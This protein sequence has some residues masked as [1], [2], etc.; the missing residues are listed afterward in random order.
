V[1]PSRVLPALVAAVAVVPLLR[2]V[3][4]NHLV[5]RT[6]TRV[7]VVDWFERHVPAGGSVGVVGW[8]YLQPQLRAAPAQ[9][10]RSSE[11]NRSQG[12]RLRTEFQLAHIRRTGAPA[13]ET[14]SFD[15]GSWR[16]TRSPEH[17]APAP[18]Q[19]VILAEHPVWTPAPGELPV[20]GPEYSLV[21][22]FQGY[23]A[24][25]EVAVFDRQDAVYFPFARFDGVTRPGP[26]L[27][28]YRRAP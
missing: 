25:A 20:L 19:H 10:T 8:N 18:P 4:W 11:A 23:S 5:R 28:V 6:D 22:T 15:R 12:H 26:N 14:F 16:D 1:N 3:Q 2:L 17:V 27:R 21:A 7:Q 9:L 13:Y 24:P